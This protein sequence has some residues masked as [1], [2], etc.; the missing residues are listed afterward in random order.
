MTKPRAVGDPVRLL[1]VFS[2]F[3]VGGPQTRFA[4]I[5]QRLGPKYRHLIIT[6]SGRSEAAGLLGGVDFE[7]LPIRNTPRNPLANM[8]RFGRELRRLRPDLLVTYNWGALEWAVGNMVI[9]GLP[10]VHIEDGFGPDEAVRRLKRRI[11]LRRIGLRRTRTL[12]VPSRN[13]ERIAREEWK[14]PHKRIAYLPNGV[15][16]ARFQAPVPLADR[17]FEKRPGELIVGTCAALRPEKNLSRLIRAFAACNPQNARLVICGEGSEREALEKAAESN[18][19]ADLMV[20]TGYLA[21]PELALCNFD[22]FAMSSDTEQM[23]YG[24]LEAMAAGLPVTATDVGDI[25]AMVADANRPFIV[26][27]KDEAAMTG[28]LRSLLRDSGLRERLGADNRAKAEREF[29]VDQ[30]IAAYDGL[31][32]S[33]AR[34]S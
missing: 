24:L 12:V 5:A 25:K 29:A 19:V 31:F 23:P 13:L 7:I 11:W 27:V 21:R 14:Q 3:A 15:D 1:H 30:M 33:A 17:A 4:T 34:G 9:G 16:I 10:H 18:G 2:T 8:L 28:A 26:P 20:F 6:M 32:D 22:I